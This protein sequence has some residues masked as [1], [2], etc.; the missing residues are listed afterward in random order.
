[1][2]ILKIFDYIFKFLL[3]NDFVRI[4]FSTLLIG[5]GLKLLFLKKEEDLLEFVDLEW[6]K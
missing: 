4:I 2:L 3:G 1:M 5:I 6:I